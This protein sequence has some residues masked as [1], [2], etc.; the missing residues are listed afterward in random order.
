MRSPPREDPCHLSSNDTTK[1]E[2]FPLPFFYC[3]LL[4]FHLRYFLSPHI[5]HL[6][7]L[8]RARA[9]SGARCIAYPYSL[10][11]P[12]QSFDYHTVPWYLDVAISVYTL[13][14]LFP[15]VVLL[16]AEN[17]DEKSKMTT[18]ATI[19]AVLVLLLQRRWPNKYEYRD[20]WPDDCTRVVAHYT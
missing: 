18:A 7:S 5:Q 6:C 3:N 17:Q 9:R 11:R 15:S 20:S 14:Q 10:S 2:T 13:R 19:K 12:R 4:F 1:F 16:S 8:I